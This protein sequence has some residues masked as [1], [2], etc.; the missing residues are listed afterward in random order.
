MQ[1][2]VTLSIEEGILRKLKH[3]AVEMD[4]SLSQWVTHVL[5]KIIVSQDDYQKAKKRA[6]KRLEKGF[7]LGG[8]PLS[9]DEIY[10]R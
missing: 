8:K 10:D 1:K 3:L 7:Y 5:E 9:R 6:L 4:Q 2:N